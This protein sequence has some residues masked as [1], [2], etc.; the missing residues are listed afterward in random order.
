[1]I[2]AIVFVQWVFLASSANPV[3]EMDDPE[4]LRP[5][6]R[7][8]LRNPAPKRVR[9]GVL[10]FEKSYE[11]TNRNTGEHLS[12]RYTVEREENAFINLDSESGLLSVDCEGDILIL[13]AELAAEGSFSVSE[14]KTGRLI[15]GGIHWGCKNKHQEIGPIFKSLTSIPV[16][17]NDP[18]SALTTITLNVKDDSPF[19]FFG[20]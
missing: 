5:W 9:P 3:K 7:A 4:S 8:L 6:M 13:Q 18:Y 19:S 20:R 17:Y 14:Y 10:K 16:I 2:A 11:R 15:Y 1:M 12:L